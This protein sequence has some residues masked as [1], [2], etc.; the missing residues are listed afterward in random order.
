[1]SI[2]TRE[3]LEAA[4]SELPKESVFRVKGFITLAD[5]RYILNYAFGRTGLVPLDP[6]DKGDGVLLTMMGE[7]G[8]IAGR[9]APHLAKALGCGLV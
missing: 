5:K 2:L 1:M 6:A 3:S 7:R 4:L 9:W 8:E